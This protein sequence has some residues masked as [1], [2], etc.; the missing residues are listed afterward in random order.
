[1]FWL[2]VSLV[3]S[4]IQFYEL[5]DCM[6]WLNT[7]DFVMFDFEEPFLNFQVLSHVESFAL[8]NTKIII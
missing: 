2:L 3:I 1:M 4:W 5:E 7:L 8:L 6:K